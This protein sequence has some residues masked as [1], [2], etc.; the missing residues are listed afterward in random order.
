[1]HA[2]TARVEG[3][4]AILI[5]RQSSFPAQVAYYVAHELGHIALGHAA[6]AAAVLDIGDP[7][8][9]TDPDEDERAADRYA[10]ELLTG[11]PDPWI[12]ATVE[13]FT[14]RSLAEAVVQQGSAYNIDPGVLALCMG[15]QSGRWAQVFKALRLM[16][17]EASDVSGQLNQ[18]AR[19]QFDWDA[20]PSDT[21]DFLETVIGGR[22]R[23]RGTDA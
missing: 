6:E 20:I 11:R 4:H 18:L 12:E 5:G 16:G 19:T 23:E 21:Q 8:R 7:L 2:A 14:A 22:D 1:M 10:L 13:R 3:R 17:G 15:H 9:P